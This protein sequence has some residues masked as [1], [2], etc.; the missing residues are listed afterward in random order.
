MWDHSKSLWL[1][2][3]WV[4]AALVCWLLLCLALPLALRAGWLGQVAGV[5]WLLFYLFSVPL[6]IVFW[7]LDRLLVNIKGGEVFAADNI[8]QLR[9]ISW[10]CFWGALLLLVGSLWDG[11]IILLSGIMGFFG[12]LMRVVK[13]VFAEAI[14]IKEEND[15]TI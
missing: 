3:L 7:C 9:T 1:S 2:E 13:N 5:F 15:Y 11:R 10:S 4:K 12:L 6:C 8:R 14:V